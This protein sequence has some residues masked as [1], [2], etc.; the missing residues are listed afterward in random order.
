MI[1]CTV[2]Q[3]LVA[4]IIIV[5]NTYHKQKTGI[6]DLCSSRS[7]CTPGTMY[8]IYVLLVLCTIYMHSWYYVLYICTP[9]TM[10]YIYVLLVLCTI[11]MH[12]W[13]YV[14]YICT[15]GTMYYIYVLLVLCTIYMCS[16]Y[17]VLC[18]SYYIRARALWL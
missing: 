2:I 9:G 10:Y 7:S 5:T 8:Y 16:W 11:Y 18:I 6:Y 13:Y 12:S 15:P 4:I 17:Y 3:Y 14:L 1:F